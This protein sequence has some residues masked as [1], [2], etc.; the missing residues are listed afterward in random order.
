MIVVAN[1]YENVTF[2]EKECRNYINKVRRLRLGTRD[3]EAIQNYFVSMQ[4]QNSQFY[5][6]MD[7]DDKSRL[8]NVFWADAR[9]RVAYK[10]FG[11]V[12]TF[13]TIY[14]TNKYDMPFAPFVGVN[15]HGQSILLGCA[16]LSNED[17][18][19]FTW[20]CTTWLECMHGRAPNA[21]IS[22]QDKAMK[23]AIEVVFLKTCHR[24][25]LWHIMKKVLE[26]FGRYSN[27]ETIKTLL[28]DVVY[29]SLSKNDFLERWEN[30][31]LSCELHDNEWLKGLYDE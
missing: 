19:N 5:Y 26:K 4:K 29:D 20:L 1:G 14:L 22:D 12:I 7:V 13:D 9:C 30:L 18:R 11:E 16:L 10:Y 3:T 27:Y 8:Q 25:C 15:H 24:W 6:V 23:N 17:T 21:I 2:G 31:I 28:H